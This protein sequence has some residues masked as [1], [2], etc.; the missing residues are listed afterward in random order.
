MMSHGKLR[1]NWSVGAEPPR[2][3]IV[4]CLECANC[5]GIVDPEAFGPLDCGCHV[6][7][8]QGFPRTLSAVM[9][10]RGHSFEDAASRICGASAEDVRQWLA[11]KSRPN[12]QF[13]NQIQHY[14]QSSG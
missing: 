2:G 13:R 10:L 14:L 1:A 11:G 6:A 5:G 12:T 8:W 4:K 7:D 3:K 9:H